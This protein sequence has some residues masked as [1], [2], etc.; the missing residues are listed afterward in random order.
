MSEQNNI[1]NNKRIAKNTIML[2]VRMLLMIVISLYTSRVV[3]AALGVDDYGI[4]NVVGGIVT[5]LSFLN[6]SMAGATQRFLNVELGQNNIENLK[7]VFATS[8]FIHLIIAGIVVGLGETLGVWFI[9]T[10][11]NIADNRVEAANYVFQCSLLSFSFTI[12]S[13]PYNASII[14]HEKMSTFAYISVVEALLKLL[15]VYLLL[16]IPFDKLKTYAI[17]SALVSVIIMLIYRLYCKYQFD[18]C[19]QIKVKPDREYLRS[20]LGFSG[21]TIFGALGTVSHTQGIGVIIN[22][23]FSVTVNAAQGIANQ[24]TGI[25]NQFVNNFMTALNPQIVKS[26]AAEDFDTM[27]TLVKRGSRMGI[28]L[29]A[30]LVIPLYLE[31]PIL[32]DIWLTEVPEYTIIFVRVIL[33]TSLSSSYAFP[34]ATA[35]AATGNIRIYQI[36][37]TTMAWMHLPLAWCGFKLGYAPQSAMY[38]Y[39]IIMNV[40]QIYRILNVCPAIGL[41]IRDFISEVLGRCGLMIVIAFGLSYIVYSIFPKDMF[42]GLTVLI[43]SFI[44]V[45][46][47]VFFIALKKQERISLINIVKSRLAVQ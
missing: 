38:I 5:I 32:L 25:V 41:S 34:L 37:L 45:S 3:L 18:E 10:Q 7:K 24:L 40:E 13:V 42:G 36:V 33:L 30:L 47:S 8:V 28:S 4:K 1:G 20:M 12:M 43:V 9:N 39:L 6:T 21:W 31:V 27:H 44:I 17:M 46:L 2:Y 26:Y 35:R 29:V 14:A 16:I 11:M 15:I 19:K 22:L 23:F